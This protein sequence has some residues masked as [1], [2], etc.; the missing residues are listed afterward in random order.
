M[1]IQELNN[2]LSNIKNPTIGKTFITTYHKL[3]NCH[4]NKVLCSVSGGSDSD[5]VLDIVTKCDTDKIV[6]YF[7][8]D[9]GLEYQ[10]TKE[11]INYLQDKYNI[12]I[13]TI[14]PNAV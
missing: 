2:L 8:F 12:V 11:H 5:I 1:T 6:E 10:A 4:Y 14:K 9:T 3:N 7:Y 13:T